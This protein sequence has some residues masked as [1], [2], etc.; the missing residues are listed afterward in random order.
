MR[1]SAG[2]LRPAVLVLLLALGVAPAAAQPAASPID[3]RTEPA[4]SQQPVT[5]VDDAPWWQRVVFYEIFV[6]SFADA[7]RGPLADDG[8]GDLQGLI[9]R[10]DYLNDGVPG[11]GDDLEIGGLWL[12]PIMDSP[13][14][15]GYDVRDYRTVE[16]DYGTRQ[17]FARLIEEA[18]RRGL[19]VILD[20][21]IN[22]TSRQHRWFRDAYRRR[23]PYHGWYRWADEPHDYLGP[24]GQRVWH[25][26]AWW[27]RGWQ[28]FD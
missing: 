13:S 9:E 15:H 7:S 4:G 10:L 28:H 21:V 2:E 8:I 24:W 14:Y 18:H 3:G 27:Q 12:M 22:H 11:S 16:R 1:R 26:L 6:R 19:R 20:L 25:Q 17:D 5:A 23:S